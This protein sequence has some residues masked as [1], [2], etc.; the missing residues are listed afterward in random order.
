MGPKSLKNRI[1]KY[2]ENKT[3]EFSFIGCH[4][5]FGLVMGVCFA[6]LLMSRHLYPGYDH[7][8]IDCGLSG[9]KP[10]VH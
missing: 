9:Q 1:T 5:K 6:R 10:Q 8:R 4:C 2:I 7:Y 3:W